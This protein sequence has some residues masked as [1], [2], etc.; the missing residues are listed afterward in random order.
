M[1]E[2]RPK[3]CEGRELTKD[4]LAGFGVTLKRDNLKRPY[5]RSAAEV[6]RQFKINAELPAPTKAHMPF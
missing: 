2:I 5:T 1:G 6:T 3:K 4:Q